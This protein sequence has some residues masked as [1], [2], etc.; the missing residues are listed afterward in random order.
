MKNRLDGKI[1]EVL[2]ALGNYLGAQSGHGALLQI[3]I[4]VLRDVEFLLNI[5]QSLDGDIT[6]S[7]ETIGNLERMNTLIQ[8]FLGLLKNG[9]GKYNDT[10]CSITDFV[11]LGCRKLDQK[12]GGLMMNLKI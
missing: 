4:V 5:I 9:T 8:K 11:I 3:L 7:L 2:L 12:L 10:S 6:S 1:S